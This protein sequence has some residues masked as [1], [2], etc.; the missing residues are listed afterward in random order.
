M[1][2]VFHIWLTQISVFPF[3]K[4]KLENITFLTLL[5][6]SCLLYVNSWSEGIWLI[7]LRKKSFNQWVYQ[8][9]PNADRVASFSFHTSLRVVPPFFCQIIENTMLLTIAPV[10]F[11]LQPTSKYV[12]KD[13]SQDRKVAPVPF[14]LSLIKPSFHTYWPFLG[15]VF[16]F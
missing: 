16:L 6:C 9:F 11:H 5:Y 1:F 2:L 12:S 3:E 10:F 8:Y 7:L 15:V 14:P 13:L 4:K